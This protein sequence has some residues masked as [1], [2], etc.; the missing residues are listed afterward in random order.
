[1]LNKYLITNIISINKISPL[2]LAWMKRAEFV[3]HLYEASR[4]RRSLDETSR[5]HWWPDV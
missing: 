2:P 4:I 5:N 1:M 3:V